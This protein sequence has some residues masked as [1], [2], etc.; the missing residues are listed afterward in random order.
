MKF[1]KILRVVK[2]I[3]FQL[4]LI[5]IPCQEN[6][7]RPSFLKGK[8]LF[9]YLLIILILKLAIVPLFLYF[10]KTIFFADITSSALL[11]LIN[12]ERENQGLGLLKENPL[13]VWA[14]ELKAEDMLKYDYFAHRSP[15]GI[16]PWHWFK[17]VGYDYKFAGE[18]L[19]I[20]FLESEEVYRAFRDSPPH[21]ANLLNEN[22]QE[23]GIAIVSG[24]FRGKETTLVVQV[25]GTPTSQAGQ[26][27]LAE[28]PAKGQEEA[29][30]MIEKVPF[31][32]SLSQEPFGEELPSPEKVRKIGLIEN[33]TK[34]SAFR[35]KEKEASW[36]FQLWRFMIEDYHLL[37]QK[38]IFYSLLFIIASLILNI[39]VK[40][41]IQRKDL[42][43]EAG[44]SIVLLF[45]FNLL[46]KA[47]I[48]RLIPHQLMI[49]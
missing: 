43:I 16:T 30:E 10:P 7:Y 41:N 25:F 42:I 48:I 13:L 49:F 29:S 39:L 9:R 3:V 18:N 15:Q 23:I 35:P 26:S 24:D 2:K 34:L 33:Q 5:F 20:G 36:G 45:L 47:I 27:V 4:Q 40:I 17:K 12:Q 38:I 6:D 44:L 8:F 22:Y 19:A 14:A 37:V 32:P 28:K 1:L 46:D 11:N 21:R 31:P